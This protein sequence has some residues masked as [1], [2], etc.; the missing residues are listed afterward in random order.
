MLQLFVNTCCYLQEPL[1]LITLINA[2]GYCIQQMLSPTGVLL[3]WVHDTKPVKPVIKK[4][5]HYP[6][7]P[8]LFKLLLPETL[9]NY[10][11]KFIP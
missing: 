7:Y 9:V 10:I 2:P 6:C 3:T 8:I 4:A 1:H 5:P 11:L